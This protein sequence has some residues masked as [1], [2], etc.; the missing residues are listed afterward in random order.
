MQ[1]PVRHVDMGQHATVA[2]HPCSTPQPPAAPPLLQWQQVGSV[3]AAGEVVGQEGHSLLAK[4]RD[5]A[6]LSVAELPFQQQQDKFVLDHRIHQHAPAVAALQNSG[7]TAVAVAGL[8]QATA[9]ASGTS[10]NLAKGGSAPIDIKGRGMPGGTAEQASHAQQQQTQQQ[11]QV[12]QGIESLTGS[13]GQ[14]N[15]AV[16]QTLRGVESSP[17]LFAGSEPPNARKG[18]VL[19]DVA[20]HTRT[21]WEFEAII[22]LLNGH[23]PARGLL[24]GRWPPHPQTPDTVLSS[25]LP[26]TPLG[27]FHPNCLP[28]KLL[29]KNSAC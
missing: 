1:V 16:A 22:V 10:A 5:A 24:S 12:G 29:I 4:A 8:S 7:S 9:A 26:E 21:S 13:L 17:S 6:V 3:Q 20:T 28:Q 2:L 23:W 14:G 15:R 27:G 25:S 18:M 19:L 11:Q